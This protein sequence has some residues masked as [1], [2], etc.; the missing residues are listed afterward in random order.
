MSEVGTTPKGGGP[1]HGWAQGEG[2]ASPEAPSIKKGESSRNTQR[3]SNKDGE[4]EKG[5]RKVRGGEN[6]QTRRHRRRGRCRDEVQDWVRMPWSGEG[7]RAE[8]V[9]SAI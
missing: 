5:S 4:V 1:R 9:E 3:R 2:M 6:V 8:T 7:S